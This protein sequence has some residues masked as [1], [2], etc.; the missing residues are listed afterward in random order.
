MK[1]LISIVNQLKATERGINTIYK[2]L[3]GSQRVNATDR[4]SS[5]LNK[6]TPKTDTENIFVEL[7]G[8]YLSLNDSRSVDSNLVSQCLE[9]NHKLS[10]TYENA[11]KKSALRNS[12]LLSPLY[13]LSNYKFLDILLKNDSELHVTLLVKIMSERFKF[14]EREPKDAES[15]Q[16]NSKIIDTCDTLARKIHNLIRQTGFEILTNLDDDSFATIS[17]FFDVLNIKLPDSLIRKQLG[18]SESIQPKLD[19]LVQTPLSIRPERTFL[20]IHN[21]GNTCYIAT[22]TQLLRPIIYNFQQRGISPIF[23]TENDKKLYNLI[24]NICNLTKRVRVDSYANRNQIKRTLL[25]LRTLCATPQDWGGIETMKLW[26]SIQGANQGDAHEVVKKIIGRLYP[27]ITYEV[28]VQASQ[29]ERK[30]SHGSLE[31]PVLS[32]TYLDDNKDY[33]DALINKISNYTDFIVDEELKNRIL[34]V[35]GR[36]NPDSNS[37]LKLIFLNQALTDHLKEQKLFVKSE[38]ITVR[39]TPFYIKNL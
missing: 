36:E 37:L 38:P 2:Q 6:Q 27:Q 30:H 34:D 3:F 20:G 11:I 21:E 24:C 7:Y 26:S 4:Y 33:K 10:S 28:D 31:Q 5:I 1:K 23:L 18:L 25:A 9:L 12:S 13:R 14:I 29:H 16:E 32:A 15:V 19:T 35:I 39:Q 8:L 22:A 17:A